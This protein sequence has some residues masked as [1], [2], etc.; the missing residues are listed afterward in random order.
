MITDEMLSEAARK[1]AIRINDSLPVPAECDHQFSAKFD[2]RMKKLIHLSNH[3]IRYRLLRSAAMIALVLFLGFG[4]VLSVSV[5]A[6]EV[7]LGWIKQQY[8]TFYQYIFVGE[9]N[10]PETS[11]YS[12]SWM[13]DGFTLIASF[14]IEGGEAYIYSDET[15]RIAQFSYSSNPDTLAM[16]IKSVDYDHYE[17]AI[18]G[19][20]ADL[21]IAPTEFE[22]SELIWSDNATGIIFC[23]SAP[24]K[25]DVLTSI[26]EK[27]IKD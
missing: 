17:T 21:Y 7:V 2:R 25:E 19:L 23:V 8:E 12:P 20:V 13:P 24:V 10:T 1:A 27:I 16:Y 9:P 26:A 14:E 3:P 18:N 11:H 6:R 22:A 5:E 15:G 4:S